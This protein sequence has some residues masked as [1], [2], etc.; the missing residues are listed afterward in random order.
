MSACLQLVCSECLPVCCVI[1]TKGRVIEGA[2]TMTGFIWV[3]DAGGVVSA[4]AASG[5]DSATDFTNKVNDAIYIY[6]YSFA[7]PGGSESWMS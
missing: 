2:L 7:L 1:V 6:A 3:S 5:L 4:K